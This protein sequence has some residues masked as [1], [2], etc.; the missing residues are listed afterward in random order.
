MITLPRRALALTAT[1]AALAMAVAAPAGAAEVRIQPCVRYVAGQQTA[2]IVGAGFTPGGLVRLTYTHPTLP[3]GM[4]SAGLATANAA[5]SFET[6]VLGAPFTSRKTQM[7]NFGVTATDVTNAGLT[8]AAPFQQVRFGATV[9]P[10]SGRTSRKVRYTTRGFQP[11]RNVYAHFRFG[12]KTRR[13]VKIGN[14]A[15]PCGIVARRMR[16]IPAERRFGEWSLYFDQ[17]RTFSPGTRPQFQ[18]SIFVRR[19]FR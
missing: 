15:G 16:L 18:T 7:Q 9:F 10:N 8:A 4:A 11:G 14:P 5:G 6:A 3:G 19:V 17:S 13:T 1:P 2:P 12:G